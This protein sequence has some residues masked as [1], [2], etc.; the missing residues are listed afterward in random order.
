MA[1]WPT[2]NSP[3]PPRP[4]PPSWTP[5]RPR[6]S[7]PTATLERL[8]RIEVQATEARRLERRIRFSN[9]PTAATI[10]D[11]DF[12]AQPG[13]DPDLIRDLASNRYLETGTNIL[14]V[15]AP[16]YHRLLTRPHPTSS[17]IG[18]LRPAIVV[19][20][21]SAGILQREWNDQR[22][23]D[24]RLAVVGGLNLDGDPRAVSRPL[25]RSRSGWRLTGTFG[26]RTRCG[27]MPGVGPV[28]D[29]PRTARRDRSV[30]QVA[31]LRWRVSCRGCVMG[32]RSSMR[33]SSRRTVRQRRPWKPVGRGCLLLPLA[34]SGFRGQGSRTVD[35]WGGASRTGTWAAAHLDA[36]SIG[37]V[38][39]GAGAEQPPARPPAVVSAEGDPGDPDGCAVF[40][41][42]TGEWM[43]NLRDRLLFALLAESGM[44]MV[45]RWA[46]GS[47]TL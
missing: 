41:S 40:D 3:P 35:A 13:V 1:T 4:S 22:W 30:D 36:R 6:T 31:F 17:T 24:V 43:G 14:M 28:V 33:W 7:A 39:V 47:V 2:S 20:S 44:R 42:G 12:D 10:E 45:K 27:V 19:A 23:R 37:S 46:C 32:A 21:L 11:F 29:L 18:S 16:R 5:R 38:V 26:H 8:L 9:L 15:E 34:R 25:R